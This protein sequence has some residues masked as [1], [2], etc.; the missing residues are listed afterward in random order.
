MPP[1]PN[2]RRKSLSHPYISAKRRKVIPSRTLGGSVPT[3][4]SGVTK[5]RASL[6]PQKRSFS[7]GRKTYRTTNNNR[8]RTGSA[9]RRTYKRKAKAGSGPALSGLDASFS[10]ARYGSGARVYRGFKARGERCSFTSLVS[11]RTTGLAGTQAVGLLNTWQASNPTD[12][13]TDNTRNDW[14]GLGYGVNSYLIGYCQTQLI[15]RLQRSNFTYAMNG[16][17]DTQLPGWKTSKFVIRN[18]TISHTIKSTTVVPIVVTLYDC[19][20][21]PQP[22]VRA[23]D[24]GTNSTA[25]VP[26]RDPLQLWTEGIKQVGFP[27][28]LTA[29]QGTGFPVTDYYGQNAGTRYSAPGMKPFTSPMF[30]RSYR[31]YKTTRLIL[32]PG[33]THIHTVKVAPKNMFPM[34]PLPR[35]KATTSATLDQNDHMYGVETFTMMVHHGTPIHSQG[36]S[37]GSIQYSASSTDVVTRARCEFQVFDKSMKE[38]HHFDMLSNTPITDAITV[39]ELDGH[40]TTVGQTTGQG[41]APTGTIGT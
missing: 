37:P 19:V 34:W 11:T 36:V 20:L 14:Y 31:V 39:D 27:D 35:A 15:R 18:L 4:A 26:W 22:P 1:I 17:T 32:A 40:L 33:Q 3:G 9:R 38:F 7:S 21:R 23:V 2:R 30:C 16:A 28:N 8:R 12:P 5:R 29:N 41:G 25:A 6:A 13:A 10:N 24:A